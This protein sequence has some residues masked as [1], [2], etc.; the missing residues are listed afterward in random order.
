M[1]DFLKDAEATSYAAMRT[2]ELLSEFRWQWV[3]L[4]S[5]ASAATDGGSTVEGCDELI[6]G[7]EVLVP[8]VNAV[9]ARSIGLAD[10]N[11]PQ[12]IGSQ[13]DQRDQQRVQQQARDRQPQGSR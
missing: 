9:L 13:R 4:L 8:I 2:P 10:G 6:S 5:K 12:D 3:D 1:R 11:Y 7:V